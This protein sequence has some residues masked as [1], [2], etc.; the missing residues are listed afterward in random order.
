MVCVFGGC[1]KKQEISKNQ[2]VV[3][4]GVITLK[5]QPVALTQEMSGRVR[6]MLTSEVRP[7]VSTIIK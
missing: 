7:Q 3:E 1:E 5:K 2:S 4:V 6:A